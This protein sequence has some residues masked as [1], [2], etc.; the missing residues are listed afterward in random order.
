M[1]GD[2]RNASPPPRKSESPCRLA[3]A[4]M[5]FFRLLLPLA[6]LLIPR[7][8]AQSNPT[9]TTCGLPAQGTVVASVTYTLTADCVLTGTLEAG[10]TSVTVTVNGGGH[11]ITGGA[12]ILFRSANMVL[13]LNNVTI[14]G[15]R[16]RRTETILV[17]TLNANS[18][19]FINNRAGP[20]VNVT[21]A[22]NL[23]NVLL[24][25]NSS[26]AFALGGNGSAVHAGANTAH[27][28]QNVVLRRNF[29]NGGA[30]SLKRGA[31][32]TTNGC[33]TLSGNL[34][35]DV[36]APTGTTW[37]NNST[38]PCSGTIGNGA[39]AVI[40]SPALM[41]CGLPGPGVLDAS[42]TYTL[43]SD[44]QLSGIIIISEDVDIRI[45]GNGNTIQSSVATYHF[46]TAFTSSLRL[47]NVELTGVRF[48]NWGDLR[49]DRLRV[50]N[51][52]GGVIFNMGEARFIN[53]LFENNATTSANGRSFLLTWS[54]YRK[55]FTSFTDSAFRNN[56]G[57]LG[58][59]QNAGATIELNGCVLFEDNTPRDISGSVT[60]NR[61]TDCDTEIV[62]PVI[63]VLLPPAKNPPPSDSPE[64]S[65]NPHCGSPPI[66][67]QEACNLKLGAIGVI[68]RP[69]GR[70]PVAQVWRIRPNPDG[71]HPPAVGTFM[72]AVN[73][74]QVEAVAEGL[75][76]CSDDG[77]VAVRTGLP[78]EIRRL[79]ELSPKYEEVLKIPRRYIVF[80]KGPTWEGKTHHVVLDRFLNGQV[81][82]TVDTYD[83]PPGGDCVKSQ[84][85]A[86]TIPLPTPAPAYAP[87]V[88]PQE[89]QPDGS[90][91]HIVQP[92]DTISAIAVAYRVH[93]LEIIMNNQLEHM[94]RWIR[95]GQRL[96]IRERGG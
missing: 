28:W 21:T 74:P 8:I 80:S 3:L 1:Y 50:A 95:P 47:E 9:V 77:R 12:F 75:V 13:N 57:G 16:Q 39:A 76:A 85:A 83:G 33:L 20:A 52:G 19:S 48:F 29:G 32:L 79:F 54:A 18:V 6:F 55:G 90:I 49:G 68:C 61:D 60:D 44:C 86:K 31:T 24:D 94:G 72:L 59:L 93:Q 82:G 69:G 23:T 65:C 81:F 96:I 11:R 67:K 42:A 36:Y 51:T 56:T 38:G 4:L 71:D 40:A 89:A 7:A 45:I 25:G 43:R 78:P 2:F 17:H 26:S 63:P 66:P 22:A 88:Q 27:V 53:G 58:V 15:G 92:G 46:R 37:T 41:G 10:Q 30:I 5:K 73:Q 14:D 35:F 70:V 64:A 91:V 87:F 62:N 84:P 34:P